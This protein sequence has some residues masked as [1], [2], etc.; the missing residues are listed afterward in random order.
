[1]DDD[2]RRV[3][4]LAGREIRPEFRAQLLELADDE[5]GATPAPGAP[6][7]LRVRETI[8]LDVDN[9]LNRTGRSGATRAGRRRGWMTLAVVAAGIAAALTIAPRVLD[10]TAPGNE[11]TPPSN[12]VAP[13]EC[14]QVAETVG[15]VPTD[16]GAVRVGRMPDGF[17]FCLVDDATG[18]ALALDHP[19][20]TEAP[21]GAPPDEPI[22]VEHGA[23]GIT[24]YFYVIDIPD[25]MPVASVRAPDGQA[26]SFPTRVGRRM[27]VIDTDYDERA[28][29][30][31]V[32]H[33]LTLY[34]SSQTVLA[35]LIADID[36]PTSAQEDP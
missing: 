8:D 33:D 29:P 31:H 15:V 11:T 28:A 16:A 14:A 21:D 22:I 24:A 12:T 34:S 3:F 2:V 17:G 26:W 4:E 23:I 10:D 32:S 36:Q 18:A 20:N 25:G 35:T 13:A 9:E 30:V 7:E 19:I 1:M 27:L 6:Q 5:P